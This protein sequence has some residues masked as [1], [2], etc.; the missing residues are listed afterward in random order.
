MIT[1]RQSQLNNA[2]RKYQ[3]SR[4]EFINRAKMRPCMDCK[5]Q[6]SPWIMHFDHRNPK[7][8]IFNIGGSGKSKSFTDLKSE[9]RKCDVVCANCHADRTHKRLWKSHGY[10]MP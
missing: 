8:K 7:E 6:Y 4:R 9:M 1:V 3:R 2:V 10:A 5:K